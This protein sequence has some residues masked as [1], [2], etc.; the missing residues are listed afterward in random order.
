[1][2]ARYLIRRLHVSSEFRLRAG[3]QSM[4]RTLGDFHETVTTPP[5][6]EGN[7][8]RVAFIGDPNVG[9]STII[10]RL[11][12]KDICSVSRKPHTTRESYDVALTT[13]ELQMVLVDTPGAIHRIHARKHRLPSE[14]VAAPGRALE[15]DIDVLAAVIDASDVYRRE[16][17][18]LE[19]LKLLHQ[20]RIEKPD[21]CSILVLNKVDAVPNK[22]DLLGCIESL[23]KGTVGNQKL[24]K[25]EVKPDISLKEKIWQ[26]E[27]RRRMK[28]AANEDPIAE[29]R[30][31]D[32]ER[33][34]ENPDEGT[35]KQRY[36]P[37]LETWTHFERVFIV[38]ATKNDGM[39]DLREYLSSRA[40]KGIWQYRKEF[41][42]KQDPTELAESIVKSKLLD[43]LD[44]EVPYLLVPRVMNWFLDDAG[45]LHIDMNIRCQTDRQVTTTLGREGRIIA[46]ISDASRQ[47]L[48][49]VFGCEVVLKLF[50]LNV[51]ST[52]KPK[53]D[54][55]RVAERSS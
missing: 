8:V 32:L 34:S 19:M 47:Q 7:R 38:S 21:G 35:Y 17:L 25:W 50:V 37:R 53:S 1:M 20:H 43:H 9:K 42:V 33:S 52:K 3:A 4:P 30:S 10:N 23:C 12:E 46:K 26:A 55:K 15:N 54:D 22:R 49:N 31:E 18:S 5:Q 51:K 11:V 29:E 41:I 45:S 40:Q 36:P 28:K 6:H 16:Y 2:F 24:R 27:E 14:M 44:R 48:C 39:D 13:D